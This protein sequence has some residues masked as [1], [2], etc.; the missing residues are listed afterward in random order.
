MQTTDA[1]IHPFRLEIPN[2]DL[3]DL[4]ARLD[5][6][7][8][9]QTL[10]GI[11]WSRGVPLDYLQRLAA[12]WRST[13]DWR[14]QEARLNNLPQFTTDID[15]QTTHFIHVRSP[16]S[17][18]MPLVLTHGYPSSVVEFLELIDPL[19]NPRAHGGNPADAFHVIIPSLPGFGLS[20]P[21][22]DTGWEARRTAVAWAELM[23]RLGY[24]RYGAH[25]GDIGAGVSGLLPAVDPGSV[26]GVHVA[27]D[28]GGAMAF[29]LMTGGLGSLEQF[30]DAERARIEELRKQAED[31]RAYLQ[32]QSTRPQTLAYGL[33]D[34]PVFQ[35]AWIVE[36]YK[37]WT[38]PSAELPEDAVD[39]DQLLATISLYWFT[40]SGATAA[41][42]IYAAA[43][44]AGDWGGPSPV[45]TGFAVFGT[46]SFARR[47]LD[48][49]GM[50]QHFSEFEA[51]RHFPSLEEPRLLIDD[52]RTFFRSLREQ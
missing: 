35:L 24:A 34:S 7:R 15:G 26:T 36:K 32:L 13:F 49:N 6:A 44:A 38:H 19:T 17:D 51:G 48:P 4:H 5:Q 40:R 52:I 46:E 11:G 39:V 1:R 43:H 9:P 8:W 41:Q 42:F 23:R 18:A 10:P 29:A 12:Y 50:I 27:S 3:D 30:S 28:P 37:E 31:G 25:G 20:M 21:L 16:E 14:A 47:L 33:T 2:A 45:P 22:S